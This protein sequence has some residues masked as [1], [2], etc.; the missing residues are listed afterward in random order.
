MRAGFTL[1]AF[2]A[3][4][5]CHRGGERLSDGKI[6]DFQKFEYYLKQ[7]N[8]Q[9]EEY[10][11]NTIPNSEAIDF[12]AEQMPLFE[13]PDED[14]ER[15][16]Y[17][18][19]WTY[20]KHIKNTPDGFV[21]TE[22]LPK[23]PW[24]GPHNTISCPAGH[25][26]YEGRWLHDPKFLEAYAQFWM[27]KAGERVRQYSFWASDAYRA[28]RMVHPDTVAVAA[29]LP[30]LV[31][32]YWEWEKRNRKDSTRLFW[33]YDSHDG[34]EVSAGG[35]LLNNGDPI[36]AMQAIR[37]TINSYM[38]GD[39]RAIAAMAEMTGQ[40]GLANEYIAKAKKIKE[41]VQQR[42]WNAD[43]EFFTI[44]P[45]EYDENTRPISVRELFGY[46]PW[47]FNLPDPG[48]GYE[49]AWKHLMDTTGFWAPYGPTTCERRH[50]YFEI[51]YE[52]H[53]CQWNGPS[54]PFAT[55]Q[56]LTA[57]ANLLNNYQQGVIYYEDY[58][59]LLKVY[60]ISQNLRKVDGQMRPWIDE[61]LNPFT[62]DWISRTRL[63][64]WENDTWS[65][66]KGGMERGKDYNHSSFND[67][68]ITGLI[69]IRPR[70]D[71]VLEVNPLLPE[72]AWDWFCLDNVK[73]RDRLVTIIWDRTGRK[74]H[75]GEGLSV[76]VDGKKAGHSQ[77][78]SRILI[79]LNNAD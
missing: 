78:L 66:A 75:L 71:E 15:T 67:L 16:W 56:T 58:F 63:M 47:Y 21:I 10:Y 54:W 20:R 60:A 48:N 41:G 65:E 44:L 24:S 36:A 12:L 69:G 77:D 57:M 23:V 35:R 70:A 11:I 55:S 50:P 61:N 68:I 22:F 29:L 79:D 17:F 53:E 43:L 7:F 27:R 33:Q 19:W 37:P 51:S 9:D 72:G 3:L 45:R 49:V 26:F 52:G 38:Y 14:L 76:F 28:F 5:S 30:D 39:A 31:K 2:L 73:Y 4:F 6:L 8:D 1:L 18:R 46:A 62:G 74:Y 13:C 40:K 64:H 25:H 34:M 42:L 32:N 59:S